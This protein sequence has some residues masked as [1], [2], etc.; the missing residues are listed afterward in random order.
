[1]AFEN[2]PVWQVV[3]LG[4]MLFIFFASGI[5]ITF[6][7]LVRQRWKRFA[8]IYED[9][10]PLGIFLRQIDKARLIT[11]GD[12]GTEYF[13]LK[14]N[15]KIR[16]GKGNRVGQNTLAWVIGDDGLWYGVHHPRFDKI[17]LELGLMPVQKDVRAENVNMRNLF[18]KKYQSK[19]FMQKWGTPIAI[20]LI[21]LA[22]IISGASN[23]YNA[24][25]QLK[26]A[27]VNL[28]STQTNERV[29]ESLNSILTK[30]DTI[31]QGGSGLVP[32]G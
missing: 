21:I 14:K 12:D 13:V 7:I 26:I 20:G 6:V 30:M 27:S 25:K 5:I 10:S 29:L 2:V 18:D 16:A 31:Q 24:D 8:L 19:D 9:K 15:K 23:W 32:A 1:M 3:V 17:R 11:L 28:E 22:I 4:I